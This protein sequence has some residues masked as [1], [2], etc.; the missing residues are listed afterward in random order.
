[1]GFKIV[2]FGILFLSQTILIASPQEWQEITLAD[3]PGMGIFNVSS[4]LKSTD[5]D[6][7]NGK[8]GGKNLFD[9]NPAT[10]WAEGK[11]DDGRNE[12]IYMV[13]PEDCRT[14]NLFN[15]YAKDISAYRKNNRPHNIS[16]SCEI[17]INPDGFVSE[18]YIV[19]KTLPCV[20]SVKFE[21]RDTLGLQTLKFPFDIRRIKKYKEKVLER[22]INDFPF[23]AGRVDLIL[24]IKILD[25]YKG[26]KWNDTCISEI[27]INQIFLHNP[28]NEKYGQID[29]I[30]LNPDENTI[31]LD[32]PEEKGL[33]MI[34][35]S[36]SV[37]QIMD[38]SID[39]QWLAVSKMP[40]IAGEGRI[41]GENLLFN[42]HLFKEMSG[43]ISQIAGSDIYGPYFFNYNNNAIFL[44][45]FIA[46]ADN[47]VLMELK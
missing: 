18:N 22:F 14:V 5:G 10:T 29:S 33:V 36:T 30:Y 45:Y 23:K 31:L 24:K 42:S 34:S 19:Y 12:I 21:L 2:F 28:A 38:N 39:N 37:F 4:S 43:V 3:I 26:K 27:F 46:G 40:A 41:G 15:G 25:V 13:I 44:E 9:E 20:D 7:I 11:K 1:M 6:Y 8:Y 32:T 47:S 17:G 35:D 16:L